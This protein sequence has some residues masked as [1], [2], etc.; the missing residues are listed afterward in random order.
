MDEPRENGKSRNVDGAVENVAETPSRKSNELDSKTPDGMRRNSKEYYRF[1]LQKSEE[2]NVQL[3]KKLELEKEIDFKAIP[4]LMQ[5]KKVRPKKKES[6][7]ITQ[8]FGSLSQSNIGEKLKK[9]GTREGG[10]DQAKRSQS[11]VT[12]RIKEAVRVMQRSLCVW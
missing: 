7:K 8:V 10:D 1:K 6:V 11:S 4:G 2:R 5:P 9:T 3:K 12:C